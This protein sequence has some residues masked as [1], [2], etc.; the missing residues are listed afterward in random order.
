MTWTIADT[1]G[2]LLLAMTI[3]SI[4]CVV[5]A[6]TIASRRKNEEQA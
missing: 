3:A 5:H 6:K 2:A 4:W 1:G